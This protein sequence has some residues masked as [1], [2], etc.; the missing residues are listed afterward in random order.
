[1]NINTNTLKYVFIV[2]YRDRIE[3]KT[4]FDRYMKYILEDYEPNTYVI[5]FA[6]QKDNRKFNRGAM[7]NIGFLYFKENYPGIY[8]DLIFIFHDVDSLPYTKNLLDY[9]CEQNEIKHFYGYKFA[10]GG[11]LSVRGY[12]FEK[13]NGFPNYWNWGFEDNVLNS[14][15][16]KN[17]VTINRDT[18]FDIESKKILHFIDDFKK[19]ISIDTYARLSNK[20]YQ[21][22]DGLNSLQNIEY[23]LN[24]EFLDISNF[25]SKYS[26]DNTGKY[27][28]HTLFDG[29]NVMKSKGKNNGNQMMNLFSKGK[30]MI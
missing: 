11:I 5:L 6:H 24:N 17:N 22:T 16:V 4:F 19:Y 25:T 28:E 1:M 21:E 23:K 15:A 29:T 8:N 18:F 9:D 3:H 26:H 12:T 27:I 20:M 7:K 10:L 30:Q 13:L 14:R 2:P